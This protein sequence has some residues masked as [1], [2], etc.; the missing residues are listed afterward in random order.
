MNKLFKVILSTAIIG[1]L[2]IS[3]NA[4]ATT[5]K[6]NYSQSTKELI[7]KFPNF[8]KSIKEQTTGVLVGAEET[9]VKFTAKKDAKIDE[10]YNLDTLKEDFDVEYFSR[11]EYK[12][13]RENSL[14]STDRGIGSQE[15]GTTN[16]L[17]LDLQVYDATGSSDYMAYNFSSWLTS[18]IFRFE[19]GI[20]IST[21]NSIIASPDPKTRAAEYRSVDPSSPIGSVKQL[22]VEVSREGNGVLATSQLGAP[23]GPAE[24]HDWMIQT[25][26]SYNNDTVKEGWITGH[27]LHKQIAIGSIAMDKN[28]IPN[29][30]IGGSTDTHSG[31]IHVSR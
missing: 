6:T 9:Y 10:S 17:R 15:G 18:P 31:S 2:S 5:V 24:Y 28:G 1:A 13:E 26:I 11:E 8:E 7:E 22:Q 3:G 30:S 16:W 20:G 23:F 29:L 12:K 27:Y 4:T 21:S 19:D 25:G 14:F